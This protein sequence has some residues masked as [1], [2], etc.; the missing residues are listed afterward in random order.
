MAAL[1]VVCVA[2]LAA[3][4]PSSIGAFGQATAAGQATHVGPGTRSAPADG[5]P[6]VDVVRRAPSVPAAVL[7]V[8]VVI[9]GWAVGRRFVPPPRPRVRSWAGNRAGRN[10]AP[11]IPAV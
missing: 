6:R 3:G 4:V 5:F 1:L 7:A 2:A 10:R 11:P 8:S 9:T